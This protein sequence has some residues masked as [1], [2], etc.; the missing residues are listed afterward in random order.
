MAVTFK[1]AATEA[2]REY[3]RQIVR[4]CKRLAE[5][6][7]AR[8]YKLAT[9]GT[10]NHLLIMDFRNGPHTGKQVAKAWLKRELSAISTWFR[11]ILASRSLPAEF[12]W[13]P[14]R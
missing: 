1:D 11:A 7:L 5:S 8:G 3:G 2:F 12:A 6:L 13:G 10:E 4:N 14:P 9:G